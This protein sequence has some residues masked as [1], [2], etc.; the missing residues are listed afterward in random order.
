[1]SLTSAR[2]AAEV[3]IDAQF[4]LLAEKFSRV[5]GVAGPAGYARR[6]SELSR[7]SAQGYQI[8]R[9]NGPAPRPHFSSKTFAARTPFHGRLPA[10][11]LQDIAGGEIDETLAPHDE[12]ALAANRS[13]TVRAPPWG[14]ASRYG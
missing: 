3:L 7:L 12:D 8:S 2:G 4:R 9:P 10:G 11:G 13:A 6:N 5:Q 14:R 1:M